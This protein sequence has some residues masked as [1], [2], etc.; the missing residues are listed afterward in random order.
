VLNTIKDGA[1]GKGETPMNVA[2]KKSAGR[3][4]KNHLYVAESE[5]VTPSW[6][7]KYPELQ[8]ADAMA[9]LYR[10]RKA[11]EAID[12]AP[13]PG[14]AGQ[15]HHGRYYQG[16]AYQAAPM[17]PRRE[18]PGMRSTAA[19]LALFALIAIGGGG[20]TGYFAAHP[21]L[22]DGTPSASVAST[23]TVDPSPFASLAAYAQRL[24]PGE[25]R[26][27]RAINTS[28]RIKDIAGHANSTIP[29]GL[30]AAENNAI[31]YKISGVPEA[32]TLTA[33]IDLGS[34]QWIVDAKDMAELGLVADHKSGDLSLRVTAMAETS[35]LPDVPIKELTVSV[36]EP[37]I[38]VIEPPKSEGK[39]VAK[40]KK[41]KPQITPPMQAEGSP[42]VATEGKSEQLEILPAAAPPT[43]QNS[44]TE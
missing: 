4:K 7:A 27:H 28:V 11:V 14:F 29:L 24:L 18:R 12:F 36:M 15:K 2:H 16:Q 1:F 22:L 20:A 44:K 25:G 23:G 42:D 21:E 8:D 10:N 17:A 3:H 13:P 40:L 30:Q 39:A 5:P 32:V 33:G 35:A 37:E 26:T 38:R 34:G 19:S 41:I 6:Y 9:E 31:N 43:Q